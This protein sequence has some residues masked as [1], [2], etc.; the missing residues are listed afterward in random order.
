M[1]DGL[2]GDIALVKAWKGDKSGNLIFR[3]AARNFNPMMATA[4]KV[5]VAEAEELLEVGQLDPDHIHTPAV[6][7]KRIFCGAPYDKQIEQP[8]VRKAQHRNAYQSRLPGTRRRL[9]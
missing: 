7:V 9:R 6:Y 1:E 4:A 8:T 2:V 5:C 3:K